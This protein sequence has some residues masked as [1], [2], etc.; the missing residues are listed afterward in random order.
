MKELIELHKSNNFI[1]VIKLAPK[2]FDTHFKDIL[3][4]NLLGTSHFSIGEYE[5]SI[6]FFIKALNIN[7]NDINILSNLGSAYYQKNDH[8]KSKEIP[9][10]ANNQWQGDKIYC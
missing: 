6:N 3:F 8:S 9:Y 7:K 5:K 2:Y 4:L 1:E 10:C